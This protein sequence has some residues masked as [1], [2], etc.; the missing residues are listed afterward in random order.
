MQLKRETLL[1][2]SE[3]LPKNCCVL[4]KRCCAA[5]HNW[6]FLARLGFGEVVQDNVA[7]RM[8][9]EYVSLWG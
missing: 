4:L 9:V 1:R 2:E 6:S 8:V 5:V 3:L 7:L